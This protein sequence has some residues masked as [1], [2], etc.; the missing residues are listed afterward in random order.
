[1]TPRRHW[2]AVSSLLLATGLLYSEFLLPYVRT[3]HI[4][5]DDFPR[6][7][8]Q[9]HV[10]VREPADQMIPARGDVRRACGAMTKAAIT[11]PRFVAEIP[12]RA[13][14]RVARTVT[15]PA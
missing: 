3:Y 14:R 9:K 6:L 8:S 5:G 10:M 15:L 11:H 12:W 1:M 4:K 13:I 2:L 7:R